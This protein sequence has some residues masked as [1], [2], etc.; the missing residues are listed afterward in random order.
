MIIV[1]GEILVDVFKEGDNTEVFPG[2]APFNVTCNIAKFGGKVKFYGAVGKDAN[3]KY[4][5]TFARRRGLKDSLIKV[6]PTRDTTQAMVTLNNGERDF[7]FIRSNGADYKL[8][9]GNFKKLNVKKDDI[10]HIGTLILSQPN[11]ASLIKRIAEYSKNIGA[12]VSIDV[13]YR[14][15]IFI[16]VR[17]AKMRYKSILKYADYLKFSED[18]IQILSGNKKL[19]SGIKKLVLPDQIVFVSMGEKGSFVYQNGKRIYQK[20]TKLLPLDT[21]GAGDGF[22]SFILY[23]LDKK[24]T[25]FKE[26]LRKAN[27]VG[28]L[29]TQTKGAVDA[30]PSL[31]ELDKF[32]IEK[33]N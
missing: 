24:E 17:I 16:S 3:G 8:T 10:V 11:G 27:A 14:S 19:M 9:F 32:L 20:T 18:E 21:T 2:G 7:R 5:K 33:E 29:V 28:A 13:N 25:D 1:V 4:L 12:K 15:D 6:L 22:Y 30:V 23:S 26:I 31:E